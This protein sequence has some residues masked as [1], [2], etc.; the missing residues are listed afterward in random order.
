MSLLS[1]VNVGSGEAKDS[2]EDH[3]SD[4][5]LV[6]KEDAGLHKRLAEI[7][8]RPYEQMLKDKKHLQLSLGICGAAFL[9]SLGFNGYL[10]TLPEQVMNWA[11]A[12]PISGEYH[13]VTKTTTDVPAIV[14][15]EELPDVGEAAFAVSNDNKK[16]ADWSKY[17]S[18]KFVADAGQWW[19]AW[20]DKHPSAGLFRTVVAQHPKPEGG[21]KWTV[22]YHVEEYAGKSSVPMREYV[23]D[24]KVTFE[25]RIPKFGYIFGEESGL[26]VPGLFCS[27]EAVKK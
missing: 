16:N 17:R 20:N 10:L 27:E 19:P 25:F 8:D 26:F 23:M 18:T 24:C 2:H 5:P 14:M 9:M 22:K 1:V 15:K 7:Y 3:W 12:D 4:E 21:M 13:V 11:L 6:R